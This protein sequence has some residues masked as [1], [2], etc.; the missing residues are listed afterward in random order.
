MKPPRGGEPTAIA[1]VVKL[2]VQKIDSEERFEE[3]KINLAWV[4]VVGA[5]AGKH[6]KPVALARKKLK[7]IVTNPGW[8]QELTMAKRGLLKK[9]QSRFGRDKIHD[10]VFKTGEIIHG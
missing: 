7:V 1:D 6:S 4:E 2:L 9:L 5:R 8:I 3:N 10:I